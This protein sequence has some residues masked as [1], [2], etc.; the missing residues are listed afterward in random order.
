MRTNHWLGVIWPNA[1]CDG[2]NQL[3]HR[4]C[5]FPKNTCLKT[6]KSVVV[7]CD[8]SGLQNLSVNR[9]ILPGVGAVGPYLDMLRRKDLRMR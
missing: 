4:K 5:L 1:A 7:V 2:N 8:P 3:W 9:I 6:S